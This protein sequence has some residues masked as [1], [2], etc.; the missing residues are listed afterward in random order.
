M[1]GKS[2]YLLAGTLGFFAV[3]SFVLAISGMAQEPGAPSES[4]LWRVLGLFLVVGALIV[5][6]IAVL[7]TMFAQ[8]ERRERERRIA[9]NEKSGEE[10]N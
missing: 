6:L 3:V 10:S 7:Q 2:L 9:R 4:S 1:Y 8:A 5:L